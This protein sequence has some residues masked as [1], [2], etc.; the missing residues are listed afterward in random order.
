MN[1]LNQI[2][3]EGNVCRQPEKRTFDGNFRVCTVPIAV[4]RRFKN[5]EGKNDEEVSYFE[6][7][8]YGNLADACEKWCPTGRGIRV[9][10]RL[11]QDR[12]TGDD[13]KKNSRI[14]V[15]AEHIE[16]KYFNK[17]DADG[18]EEPVQET[19]DNVELPGPTKKQK[20]AMLAE[21]AQATQKDQESGE[22]AF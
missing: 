13:G 4:S 21:A 6:I 8:T 9:V 7:D 17:K 15:I 2:I 16:F 5:R 18:N 22:L 20:L 12:W 11:K 3:L 14:K 19:A 10:G 1:A